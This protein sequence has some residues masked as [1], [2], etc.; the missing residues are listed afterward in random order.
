MIAI[1]IISLTDTRY[2]LSTD[3]TRLM[4]TS[5][6]WDE[7]KWA[8]Q[9]WRDASGKQIA[10]MYQQNAELHNKAAKLEGKF[11]ERYVL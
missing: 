11:S 5:R 1:T 9:G 3:L 2:H 7:L 10:K 4:A 8:W 6:D